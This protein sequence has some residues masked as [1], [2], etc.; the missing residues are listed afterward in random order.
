M[1]LNESA[2]EAVVHSVNNFKKAGGGC[3]VENSTFGL[4]RNTAF[5]KQLSEETG[6]HI[7]AGTGLYFKSCLFADEQSATTPYNSFEPRKCLEKPTP[8]QFSRLSL[9]KLGRKWH[10][11]PLLFAQL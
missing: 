1:L 4:N 3:L 9:G 10:Q 11:M 2:E 5:L 8:F 6:V 7:I